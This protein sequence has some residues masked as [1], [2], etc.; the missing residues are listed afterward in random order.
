MLFMTILMTIALLYVPSKS[1]FANESLKTIF[2]LKNG[3]LLK[4]YFEIIFH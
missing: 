3:K 2:T 1:D 4:S